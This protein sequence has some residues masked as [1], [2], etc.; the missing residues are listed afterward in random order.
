[1]TSP[2]ASTSPPTIA[3]LAASTMC[4]RGVA[5]NVVRIIPDVNSLS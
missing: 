4:R 5:A 3:A 2:T 1:M